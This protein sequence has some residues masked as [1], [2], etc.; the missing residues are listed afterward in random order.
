MRFLRRTSDNSWITL[1]LREGR[2]H[3]VK[4]MCLAAGHP[5]QKLRR[6]S[7]AGVGLGGLAPGGIRRL[8]PPEVAQL[9]RAVREGAGEK[10]LAGRGRGADGRRALP[11][12]Q[13]APPRARGLRET[14]TSGKTGK[15]AGK[16]GRQARRSAGKPSAGPA[17]A[18]AR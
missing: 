7:Y 5:V 16:P 8:T 12:G 18:R 9:R 1:T 17:A 14:A 11:G 2:H 4:R 3:E 13:S 10:P 15:P 6:V